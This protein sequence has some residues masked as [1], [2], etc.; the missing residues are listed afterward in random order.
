M[1]LTDPSNYFSQKE[2]SIGEAEYWKK[3]Y[4]DLKAEMSSL[5]ENENN[6]IFIKDNNLNK[7]IAL[8]EIVL[9]T[10]ESNYTI[11]HTKSGE[12]YLTS[13]TL[14]YWSKKV[15]HHTDFR[16]VHR[17]FLVNKKHI[18][19]FTKSS[20]QLYLSNYHTVPV[21]RRCQFSEIL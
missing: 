13:F 16:R 1:N 18:V 14:K 20:R 15:S 19:Y 21:A 3:K 2:N 4:L 6:S 17:S 12:Q 11:I 10:A 5:K 8:S 7:N 9:F